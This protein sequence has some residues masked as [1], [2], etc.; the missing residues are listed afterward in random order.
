MKFSITLLL[1][2]AAMLPAQENPLSTE[3]KQAF[4]TIK[5]NLIKM[6]EKMPEDAYAFKPVP[7]ICALARRGFEPVLASQS[8]RP[9]VCLVHPFHDP[10]LPVRV[11]EGKGDVGPVLIAAAQVLHQKARQAAE[12]H[13][14]LAARRASQRAQL[15]LSWHTAVAIHN[16]NA[17]LAVEAVIVQLAEQDRAS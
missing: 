7:E 8:L 11:A 5:N 9:P 10:T 2:S 13:D 12:A 1:A 17:Q 3:A 14:D 15:V 16:A 6:A 4:N